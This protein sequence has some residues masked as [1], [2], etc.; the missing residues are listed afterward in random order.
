MLWKLQKLYR[1]QY[2]NP[3][4]PLR[5][6]KMLLKCTSVE[7]TPHDRASVGT[8][9]YGE[10]GEQLPEGS[11]ASGMIDSDG[12]V[13]ERDNVSVKGILPVPLRWIDCMLD[14]FSKQVP[15]FFAPNRL[16][17]FS[18]FISFLPSSSPTHYS[19]LSSPLACMDTTLVGENFSFF[20]FMF[21]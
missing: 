14:P 17:P 13:I 20:S 16:L 9:Q 7:T 18:F 3:F 1:N 5:H 4:F 8:Q 21:Y 19:K 11:T 10:D 15:S 12:S 6:I 2:S